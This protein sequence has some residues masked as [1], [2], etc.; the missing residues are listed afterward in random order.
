MPERTIDTWDGT[1][2]IS[3]YDAAKSE[4]EITTAEQLAGMAELS[5]SQDYGKV[6][7]EG[8]I[9]RLMN[10]LDLSDYEWKSIGA[11]GSNS[12]TTSFAGTFDGQ[13]HVVY[14]LSTEEAG[15]GHGLFG[16]VHRGIIK[17]LGVENA[18]VYLPVD[19]TTLQAGILADWANM[20]VIHN[21][22]TTGSIVSVRGSAGGSVGLGGI[23]GQCTNVTEL[24]GCYSSASVQCLIPV[25]DTDVVGG[26][27]GQW[28]TS[29]KTGTRRSKIQDSW[30]DGEIVCTSDN[31]AVG[32]ILGADFTFG[33]DGVL[34]E[35]CF[36]KPTAV[37]LE[38]N[39]G[40]F[41]YIGATDDKGI[42][43]ECYYS[44]P[45]VESG[46]EGYYYTAVR[47]VVDWIA[48]EAS[49]DPDFV[50]DVELVEDMLS[51]AFLHQLNQKASNNPKVTWVRGGKHPT[52]DW[53][54]RNQVP[55]I[56]V[57]ASAS[58]ADKAQLTVKSDLDGTVWYN[59]YE[60]GTESPVSGEDLEILVNSQQG[61][62]YGTFDI[63]SNMDVPFAVAGLRAST[64]YTV[65][66]A[67][68][69]SGGV[70]SDLISLNITTMKELLRG[71]ATLS[72][73]PVIGEE[74]SVT[75]ENVQQDAELIYTWY[76]DKNI[77]AGESSDTYTLQDE[78]KKKKIYVEVTADNYRGKL[79]SASSPEIAEE[80]T[81]T[82]I[83]ITRNPDRVAYGIGETFDR[84]GMEVKA[85][86]K[87]SSS[88][89]T[90]STTVKFLAENEYDVVPA[91]FDESGDVSV[92][93][94]YMGAE[95]VLNVTVV[96]D[97]L[98]GTVNLTGDPVIGEKLA[99]KTEGVQSDA[100]L[101]YIWY[102]NTEKITNASGSTYILQKADAGQ[103]IHVEVTASNYAGKL[104][105]DD[106]VKIQK[107]YVTAEIKVT[108]LPDKITY[109]ATE[110]FDSAGMEVTAYMKISQSD[111]DV[112]KERVLSGQEY[113]ISCNL[114]S[115][116]TVL[117]TVLY[118][119]NGRIYRD[120]FEVLVEAVRQSGDDSSGDDD[121]GYSQT[122]NKRKPVQDPTAGNWVQLENDKWTFVRTD[123]MPVE[124][125]W[126]YAANGERG[127]WYRFDEN[128]F[129]RYGWYLDGDGRWYYLSENHDGTFG[130]MVTGWRLMEDGYWYY[131]RPEDGSMAVDWMLLNSLWYYLNPV[132]TAATW[133]QDA[134]GAWLWTGSEHL[135]Y[136]AMYANTITP[137]GWIV[138]ADGAMIG[139]TDE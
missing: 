131:L 99:A 13:N 86:L 83:E 82:K 24:V 45:E 98:E 21:C 137:D 56:Y 79:V 91:V 30:F 73:F 133:V 35:N 121:S 44:E 68:K 51:P 29:R 132:G 48:G 6:S 75:V 19:D 102:R 100:K 129:M 115:A 5:T 108:K 12:S 109:K 66:V 101:H 118:Q 65:S 130:A 55:D 9:I 16:T 43:K 126:L 37:S 47:L 52:F 74:L 81:V 33:N 127:D 96:Q 80:Y 107:N 36:V 70:W 116:G 71:T 104:V 10:D 58:D 103:V 87:A 136:G 14:N 84:T 17:N 59:I 26:L 138:G 119:E 77:I 46:N 64:E 125:T 62:A 112:A 139:K 128:G 41:C 78:D 69:S 57:T 134:N 85:Y 54:V 8:K 88:N 38:N 114:D 94:T 60:N 123:G 61:D 42:I 7:F 89:A 32:G 28:E 95:A 23:V 97:N 11:G 20:A 40:N 3:W 1:A 22:Y 27:V 111:P 124:N 110:N 49:P 92:T 50:A 72:G 90:P 105:S 113:T 25:N 122:K 34:I 76:R 31:S 63:T 53:D 93:V 2:D 67:V 18:K 39:P 106:T 120:T 15:V 117:V 4:F 135:P